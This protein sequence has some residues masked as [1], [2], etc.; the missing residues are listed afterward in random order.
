MIK[1]IRIIIWNGIVRKNWWW[2]LTERRRRTQPNKQRRYI[3]NLVKTYR[4][5]RKAFG[6]RKTSL[7]YIKIL[8]RAW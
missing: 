3:K 4:K 8:C 1:R 7:I 6:K 2:N 5:K